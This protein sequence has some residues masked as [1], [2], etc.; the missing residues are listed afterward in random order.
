MEWQVTTFPETLK[1]RGENPLFTNWKKNADNHETN[2]VWL[3]WH[4]VLQV[5]VTYSGAWLSGDL[6][7]SQLQVFPVAIYLVWRVRIMVVKGTE[8]FLV[9]VASPKKKGVVRDRILNWSLAFVLDV[10][11]C[12]LTRV[13]TERVIR[14]CC[15][16]DKW[17]SCE[18]F[19]PRFCFLFVALSSRRG[20]SPMFCAEQLFRTRATSL[21]ASPKRFVSGF[22]LSQRATESLPVISEA[23]LSL[24]SLFVKQKGSF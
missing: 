21:R 22:E 24:M 7:R 4:C 5:C 2:Q 14:S 16:Q 20:S 8:A 10:I 13:V 23:S 12:V 1:E 6:H 3:A 11:N 9:C 19:L 15:T 17:C 18:R